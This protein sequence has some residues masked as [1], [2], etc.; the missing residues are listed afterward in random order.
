VKSSLEFGHSDA[1]SGTRP[2]GVPPDIEAPI[3]PKE[4]LADGRDSALDKA[5][6][7]I[8]TLENVIY[9]C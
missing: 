1:A 2:A 5:L 3:F 8:T 6:E 4:D 7:Q 9:R